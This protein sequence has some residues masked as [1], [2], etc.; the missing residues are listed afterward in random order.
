MAPQIMEPMYVTYDKEANA[1]YI[2]FAK[3]TSGEVSE[4]IEIELPE[5]VSGD[6]NLDLDKKGKILGVE[7]LNASEIL[8]AA[9]LKRAKEL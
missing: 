9:L 7:V 6:L 8:P 3:V 5:S 4:T 1:A 2:G